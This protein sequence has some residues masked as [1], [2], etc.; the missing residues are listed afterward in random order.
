MI[1]IDQTKLDLTVRVIE[2]VL[3]YTHAHDGRLVLDVEFRDG[4]QD[5]IILTITE[6]LAL[7]LLP[8]VQD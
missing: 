6:L 5:V 2:K 1:F 8:V 4:T 3:G 7:S